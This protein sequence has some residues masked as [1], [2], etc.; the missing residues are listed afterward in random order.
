MLNLHKYFDGIFVLNM[1]IRPDRWTQFQ[2]QAEAARLTGFQR[3]RAI[4]GDKCPHPAWWRA[5]NGA[6]G[7]LMSHA[8]LAQD[9][10]LDGLKNYLVFEDDVVFAPD[11]ADR[12]PVLM[13]QLEGVEWDQLYLGGQHMWVEAGPPWPYREGAVR[14]PNV[15]RTHAFAVNARF[16]AKFCQHI[17]HFPDYTDRYVAPRPAQEDK[18]EVKEWMSHIDHQL[19]VLH[20]RR[21]DLIL[22]AN[23]WLCG[24]AA[25]S[26]NISGKVTEAQWW[27][28]TGWGE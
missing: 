15:N 19:G 5:G 16:M 6:W 18:P 26:S 3:Y 9:A 24:Q 14:C 17:L 21:Q 20:E 10:A 13:E 22:A 12:L 1:D 27:N 7:C 11:F 2:D 23:P 8:R 28:S 4:E 25:G